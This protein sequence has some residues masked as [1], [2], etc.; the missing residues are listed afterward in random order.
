M[1]CVIAGITAMTLL[2]GCLF[3]FPQLLP[4]VIMVVVLLGILF[5]LNRLALKNLNCQKDPFKIGGN[6]RNVDY[7]I[8][9]DMINPATVVPANKTYVQIK[10]PSRSLLASFEILRHTSSILDEDNGNVVI[11]TAK[12]NRGKGTYS[13][14][15]TPFFYYLTIKKKGLETLNKLA[16]FPVLIKPFSTIQ[17]VLDLNKKWKEA[18]CPNNEIVVFCSKRNFNLSYYEN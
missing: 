17:L 3:L 12:K 5:M 14:F 10:A 8:I 15:D 4:F 11:C 18:A 13:I 1:A 16:R 2:V 6:V 9:G 7:L